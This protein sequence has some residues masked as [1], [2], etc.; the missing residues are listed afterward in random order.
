VE[1]FEGLLDRRGV[2]PA[3]DLVEID[4]IGVSRRPRL[5]SMAVKMALRD[6]PPPFGALLMGKKTLVASTTSSRRA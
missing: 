4:V 5:A 1:R 6:S 2:V 3:V